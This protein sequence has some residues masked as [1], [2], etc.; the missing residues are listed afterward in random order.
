MHCM[1]EAIICMH[2]VCIIN[3]N[4]YYES[5]PLKANMSLF[6]KKGNKRF[7]HLELGYRPT[8]SLFELM[9]Q[10]NNVGVIFR[11]VA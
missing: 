1:L 11:G 9:F 10:N 5:W 6:I 2:V 4:D 8:L 3:E 7:W